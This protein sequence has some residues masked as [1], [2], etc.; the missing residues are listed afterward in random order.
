MEQKNIVKTIA[1]FIAPL[2]LFAVLF[3]PYSWLN[4]AVIVDVFGC[5]CPQVNEAGEIVHPTFNAN[6]FTL[7]FWL[8]ISACITAISGFL[9]IKK[10]PGD[11]KWLR[12]AYVAG[13]LAASIFMSYH[14][15]QLMMWN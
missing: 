15:L 6:D 4:S 3:I 8:F 2:L 1:I 7:L 5:G 10:I 13:M 11:R 14:F 12:V 9:S